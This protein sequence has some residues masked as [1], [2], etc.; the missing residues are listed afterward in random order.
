[1]SA[2][3][4]NKKP[5]N[6]KKNWRETATAAQYAKILELLKPIGHSKSTHDLRRAGVMQPAARIKELRDRYGYPIQRVALQTIWDDWGYSHRGVAFY[7]II[8]PI[9]NRPL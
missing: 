6:L 8:V 9:D 5:K 3:E 4:D 7:A 1:M 2:F